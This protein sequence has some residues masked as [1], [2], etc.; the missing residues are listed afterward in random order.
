[1]WSAATGETILELDGHTSTINALAFSPDD[2]QL[3]SGSSD[4]T[5]R[6][7]DVVTG[8]EV[9]RVEFGNSNGVLALCYSPDG[10]SIAVEST[11]HSRIFDTLRG[12]WQQSLNEGHTD[13]VSCV[14]FSPSGGLMVSGS[15]DQTVRFWDEKTGQGLAT[16]EAGG[17][18]LALSFPSDGKVVA[19]A[20]DRN[21]VVVIDVMTRQKCY[22]IATAAAVRGLSVSPNAEMIAVSLQNSFV[23]LLD[24]SSFA[25]L[26]SIP[27]FVFL[28]TFPVHPHTT[29]SDP[30]SCRT[31]PLFS[32]LHVHS[33]NQVASGKTL[34]RLQGH[35]DEALCVALARDGR[36]IASGSKDKSVRVYRE[37]TDGQWT[38]ALL[39]S[40]SRSL[41][42]S[43]AAITSVR[44]SAA[45]KI[46]LDQHGALT[47]RR[48][49]DSTSA[50]L[51]VHDPA[52]SGIGSIPGNGKIADVNSALPSQASNG[53][54][55]ALAGECDGRPELRDWIVC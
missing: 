55:E 44:L 49:G 3:V 48:I 29:V 20:L 23:E 35:K 32:S 30:S 24:V 11:A 26:R 42:F 25:C 15:A 54:A 46:V 47:K 7:W 28:S 10:K 13:R 21:R 31:S 52:P 6:F 12:D 51:A 18:V 50:A 9:R 5:M 4:H 14:E 41:S 22:E 33:F 8:K 19:A 27:D 17:S 16:V 43:D 36:V 2:A 45:N 34:G 37:T 1:M 38:L 40:N 39:L 53:A